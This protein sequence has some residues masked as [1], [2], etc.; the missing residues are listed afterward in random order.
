MTSR[1]AEKLQKHKKEIRRKSILDF[2]LFIGLSLALG[3]FVFGPLA[4]VADLLLGGFAF[5]V[6]LILLIILFSILYMA[7]SLHFKEKNKLES[8]KDKEYYL[9][10]APDQAP[11]IQYLE[12]IGCEK[13]EERDN[14]VKLETFASY[15]DKK[16][17]RSST[18]EIEVVNR[19]EDEETAI[20]RRN[21]EDVEKVRTKVEE[22]EE[23]CEVEEIGV[24]LKRHSISYME[25]LMVIYPTIQ[26]KVLEVADEEL[27]LLD[28]DFSIGL[29]KFKLEA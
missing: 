13:V 11:M 26:R 15:M 16:L 28:E 6:T 8:N 14:R 12:E 29:S 21:G 2:L 17:G 9:G 20:I 27:E 18:I 23:S 25:L 7:P 5:Q 4:S 24:S 1:R 10:S 19:E 22:K 3:V